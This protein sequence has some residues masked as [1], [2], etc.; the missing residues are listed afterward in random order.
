MASGPDGNLW[1]AEFDANKIA[2]VTTAGV[3]TEFDV[4]TAN[5][6]PYLMGAGPDGN[7]WFTEAN[8]N[9]IGRITPSGTVTEFTL[10]PP[11]DTAAL[12]PEGITAGPD[13]NIWFIH[14]GANVVCVMS[15]AGVLLH[16]Y[17]IPTPNPI[18]NNGL[19]QYGQA[20]FIISGPDQ[21]LWFVEESGNKIGQ[22]TTSG[23]ITEFTIPTAIAIPKNL[24]VA[25]DGTMWFPE[26]N[27]G[28]LGRITTAGVI[29]EFPGVGDPAHERLRRLTTT[30]DGSIWVVQ[31]EIKPP[32][33][34]EIGEFNLSGTETNLWAFPGGLPRAIATGPDGNPWFADEMNDLVI[35]L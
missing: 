17:Q 19:I 29:T 15:T 10:P 6:G 27:V 24:A 30:P 33:N 35:R 5:A 26:I 18:L 3:V 14:G 1:V 9:L 20:T 11:L 4:P 28:Q 31:A 34:S 12:G 25:S 7:V 16:T 23:T 2:R 13:G 8:T 22:I 21:N 32:W